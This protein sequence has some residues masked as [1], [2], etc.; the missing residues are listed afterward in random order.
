MG[1]TELETTLWDAM[2]LAFYSSDFPH[3]TDCVRGRV[4][5]IYYMD[6]D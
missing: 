5:V 3:S 1:I 4:S 2:T 6:P